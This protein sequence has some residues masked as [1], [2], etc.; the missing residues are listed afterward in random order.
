MSKYTAGDIITIFR[1]EVD[2]PIFFADNNVAQP[3]TLWSNYQLLEWLTDGQEEFAERTACFKDDE[4]FNP[5]VTAGDPELEYDPRILRVE[6]AELDSTE[7]ELPIVTIEEFRTSTLRDDYGTRKSASWKSLEGTPRYLISDIRSGTFRLYPIPTEDDSITLT[8]R[9]YPMASL[10]SSSDDLELPD[11]WQKGL[12]YKLAS[13]A[14]STPKA[15][16]S[17]F[18]EAGLIAAKRWE[19]HLNKACSRLGI[20]DRGPGKI[21]YGGL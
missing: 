2:D 6:K 7:R 14:Y 15:M 8:V 16:M 1:R 12:V 3:N 21:R 11:R 18:G 10:E 20:R 17:G 4:S 9:R 13:E 19:D 5:T